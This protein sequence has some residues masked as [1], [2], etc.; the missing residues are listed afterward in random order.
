MENKCFTQVNVSLKEENAYTENRAKIVATIA[1]AVCIIAVISML[2][3]TFAF[4]VH[5]WTPSLRSRYYLMIIVRCMC[6]FFSGLSYI[7]YFAI[8]LTHH[9][10]AP[11][12]ITNH[13]CIE[14]IPPFFCQ[15][16]STL[17]LVASTV[18]RLV[19]V[20]FP[21]FY[22]N[23]SMHLIKTLSG[24]NVVVTFSQI[25]GRIFSFISLFKPAQNIMPYLNAATQILATTTGFG[26]LLI[27]LITCKQFHAAAKHIFVTNKFTNSVFPHSYY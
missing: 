20:R 16:F 6:D 12:I 13:C 21:L 14:L 11:N 2:A 9:Q 5:L 23:V 27:Y 22:R 7:I 17:L 19:A 15:T 3:S 24:V 1:T 26:N 10:N 8:K 4:C 18:D 25:T